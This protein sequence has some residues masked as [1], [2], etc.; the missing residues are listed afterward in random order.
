MISELEDVEH[1]LDE[2]NKVTFAGAPSAAKAEALE[3]MARC[4]NQFDAAKYRAMWAFEATAEHRAEGHVNATAW[5][6]SH[7]REEGRDAARW[8]RVARFLKT[9]PLAE[10]ALADGLITTQPH[11]V[12]APGPTGRGR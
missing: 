10:A 5:L 1:A 3:G 6:K 7:A 4:Q 11:R 12:V 8:A 9:L 2:L